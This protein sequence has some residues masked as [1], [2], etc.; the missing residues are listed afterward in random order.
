M[1]GAST[2][3]TE[4][5]LA[6]IDILTAKIPPAAEEVRKLIEELNALNQMMTDAKVPHIQPTNIPGRPGAGRPPGVDDND[7]Q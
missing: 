1:E 7:Q 6:Q 2:A 3:P 5:E 4:W